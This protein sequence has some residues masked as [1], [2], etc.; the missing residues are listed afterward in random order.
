MKENIRKFT[1]P[2]TRAK[3]HKWF[4]KHFPYNPDGTKIREF[5]LNTSIRLEHVIGWCASYVI[6]NP[7]TFN[8][9]ETHTAKISGTKI[10]DS[11]NK[12]KF[13]KGKEK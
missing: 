5:D 10:L 2:E 9:V 6:N 1:D 13:K 12:R 8:Q 11:T 4:E 3:V 7:T